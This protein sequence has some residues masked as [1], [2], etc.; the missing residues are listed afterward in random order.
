MLHFCRHHGRRVPV[1][2]LAVTVAAPGVERVIN[3]HPVLEHR[4][5][6]GINYREAERHS[7][8]PGDCGVSSSRAVSAPRTISAS[9]SSARFSMP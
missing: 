3:G 8:Q 2:P 6:I 7:E 4:V 1:V 5:V 9:A